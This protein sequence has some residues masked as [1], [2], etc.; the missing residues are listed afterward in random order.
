MVPHVEKAPVDARALLWLAVALWPCLCLMAGP[1]VYFLARPLPLAVALT[2]L[3]YLAN[4]AQVGPTPSVDS[5][6]RSGKIATSAFAV[7]TLLLSQKD[8]EL[9][10]RVVSL[11]LTALLLSVALCLPSE[12][13]LSGSRVG[14]AA[15]HSA[16]SYS[17]GL[18]CMAIAVY[19]DRARA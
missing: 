16:T 6:T 9:R 8:P 1:P 19:L 11:V 2:V 4:E 3:V 5:S 14:S 17:A 10:S 7:A 12:G 18:L 15:L 13:E